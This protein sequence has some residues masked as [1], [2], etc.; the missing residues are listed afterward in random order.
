M[1]KKIF[2]DWQILRSGRR[3]DFAII[4]AITVIFLFIIAMN[5]RLIY[6]QTSNQAEEIGQMQLEVIRGDFQNSL[7]RAEDATVQLSMETEQMLRAKT[8]LPDIEK[9]FYKRKREQKKLTGGVCF[10]AYIAN[11]DW[12]IIPDFDMPPDYHAPERLWY[13][14]AEENFGR[15]YITEPYVD[16]MTGN[17]CYTMSR[18]LYDQQTVVAMDF[19]FSDVQ[20]FI[21]K[22]SMNKNRKALIVTKS[23]MIIGYNDMKLVGEKVSKPRAAKVL[24]RPLTAKTIRF[25]STRRRMIGTLS[26]ASTI[27]RFTRTATRK[28]FSRR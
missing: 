10:N 14:G 6:R 2:Q 19:N 9:F 12:S 25:F 21:R 15:T 8:P 18:M 7:Y 11:K 26:W 27:G 5:V 23:G 22:M 28:F 1:R 3:A 4:I 24:P 20:Y 13:K 17:M 16:A